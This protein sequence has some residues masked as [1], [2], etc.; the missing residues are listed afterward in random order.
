MYLHTNM[1]LLIS[2][3]MF[4]AFTIIFFEDSVM[5]PTNEQIIFI[6]VEYEAIKSYEQ[7]R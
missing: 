4:I 5:Q 6:V 7:V 3:L 1:W 2:F